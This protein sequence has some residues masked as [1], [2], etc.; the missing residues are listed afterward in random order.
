MSN[1]PDDLPGQIRWIADQ[2]ADQKRRDRNRKRTGTVAEVDN[3]K[4]LARVEISERDGR[5]YLSPWIPWG[6]IAAGDTKTH[7]APSVGQQVKV[8][9]ET[10]DLTD[11]EID[12]SVPSNANPRPHDGPEMVITRG[13]VR[14]FIAGDKVT[15]DAPTIT[16][17]A[18]SITYEAQSGELA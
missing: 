8:V 2:L 16:Y 18:Q 3:A 5:K 13:Q 6:E 7:I 15:L 4:G 10:G 9:S 11:A 14:L 1:I 12:M 17:K